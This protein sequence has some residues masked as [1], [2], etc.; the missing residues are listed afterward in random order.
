MGHVQVVGH[1][2]LPCQSLL[3][4]FGALVMCAVCDATSGNVVRSIANIS[5]WPLAI[6]GCCCP[7]HAAHQTAVFVAVFAPQPL[8]MP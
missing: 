1:S 8:L 3:H 7:D 5:H 2:V 6:T 4:V